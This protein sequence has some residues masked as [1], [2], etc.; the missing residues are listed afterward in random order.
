MSLK[1]LVCDDDR[2]IARAIEIYLKNAGYDTCQAND[3]IQ[4]IEMLGKEEIQL[5]IMDIKIGSASCR[6][7]V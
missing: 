6:E 7:R 4:A 5:V 3:G 2:E 1:I